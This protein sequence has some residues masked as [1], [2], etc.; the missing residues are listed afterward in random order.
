MQTGARIFGRCGSLQNWWEARSAPVESLFMKSTVYPGLTEGFCGQILA[1]TSNLR[2]SI[3][4]KLGYSPE[5]INPGDE[6]HTFENIVK[7]VSGEDAATAA[8]LAK[9]YGAVVK[10][11]VYVAS[12]IKTAETAKVLENTQRDL[13]IAL[14]NELAIICDH[15]GIRTKD[16][17]DAANT[18]WNFLPFTP[19]LVGGHCIGVDPYYL[20]ARAQQLGYHPEV[21]LA[22]RRVN[23]GMGTFIAR[24][25]IRFLSEASMPLCQARVG[26]LGMTFKED[27]SDVR[28]S[29]IPD[30]VVEFRN[31]GI[32]PMVCDV[33]ANPSEVKHEYGI[34]LVD[35]T[36]VHNLDALVLAV[37]HAHYR[38]NLDS[39]FDRLRK[40]G[41][42]IDVKSVLK[43]DNVPTRYRYWSL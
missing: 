7:V 31:Y 27:V 33:M 39:L 14:M 10:A 4:F 43:P 1:E 8:T 41:L 22:G 5:R 32:T 30:I 40:G 11:G 35:D 19:G 15:M 21:I 34:D 3:D 13:N 37:P 12:T 6:A 26:I 20:T 24:R 42:L 16:V 17:L 9:L 38:Q 25:T 23:D 2:Q 28:N 36:D 18:K 29:R